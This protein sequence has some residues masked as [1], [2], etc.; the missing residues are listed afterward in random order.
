MSL[1]YLFGNYVESTC[2]SL[3]NRFFLQIELWLLSFPIQSVT[4][5]FVQDQIT[6]PMCP[7]DTNCVKQRQKTQRSTGLLSGV[8]K[9]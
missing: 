3:L 6:L 7:A 1:F 9:K 4:L 8:H 5:S 2:V